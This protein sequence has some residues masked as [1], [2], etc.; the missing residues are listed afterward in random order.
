MATKTHTYKDIDLTFKPHPVTR[1]LIVKYD[2]N[3]IKNA[4]KNL[5]LTRHY[6]HPFHSEIGCSI[7]DM[8]FENHSPAIVVLLKT[9]ITNIIQ[10]FEPRVVVRDVIV[11]YDPDDHYINLTIIFVIRDLQKPIKLD[12]VLKRTR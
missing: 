5:V 12:L 3:S 2:E 9:E 1:D 4:V 8:L 10:N 6:E 7:S 11:D